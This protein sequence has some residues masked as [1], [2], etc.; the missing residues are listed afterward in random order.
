MSELIHVKRPDGKDCPA[1]IATPA[2][3]T[4]GAVV[5]IQEWW[6][7]NE[8]ITGTA[9]R[10]AKEGYIALVPDLFRGKVA[11]DADEANHF[12]GELDFLDAAQQDVRGCVQHLKAQG[13]TKAAVSGFCMGGAL[14][15]LAAV[16]VPEMDAGVC[17]YG[18]PPTAALDPKAIRAPLQCHF[19]RIDDWCTPEAV[20]SLER[21]L[22]E[23]NVSYELYRYDAKH[24]FMN[25][26]RPEVYDEGSAKQ[27]WERAVAFLAK[28]VAVS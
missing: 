8:Q 7:L 21:K 13:A 22:R 12:M 10:F 20:D 6:G 28:H 5:V 4:K 18:I 9:D 27:A 25:E 24:A 3:S 17:F 23:G 1:Y 11:K 16:S 19:A 2:G 15:L 14:T 26:K